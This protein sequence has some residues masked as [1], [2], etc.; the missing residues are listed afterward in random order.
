MQAK[1]DFFRFNFAGM[2]K[3]GLLSLFLFLTLSASSQIR[4]MFDTIRHDL[5]HPKSM[6][7]C[8]DGKNSVI[9]DMP[10]KLFGLQFGYTYN[11]RT[12]LFLGFYRSYNLE[13]IT[14]NPSGGSPYDS[15]TVWQRFRLSYFNMGCEYYFY[16]TPKWRFSLPFAIGLGG[17]QVRKR[18]LNGVFSDKHYTVLPVELGFTAGYKLTWWV[19]ISGGIG[20]RVS[21]AS[22]KFNG[23]YYYFGLSFRFGEIYNRAREM[24]KKQFAR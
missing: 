24:H 4:H 11:R 6:F 2:L 13:K 1:P 10:V 5:T 22:S 3:K 17:G 23:S 19:W 16:N 18:K 12:N 9:R 20:T 7:V 8:L 15:N 14:E 21:L